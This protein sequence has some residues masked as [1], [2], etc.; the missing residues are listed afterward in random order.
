MNRR[1]FLYGCTS[2]ALANNHWSLTA[3]GLGGSQA[4][5]PGNLDE[6]L[7]GQPVNLALFG[8]LQSW[9]NPSQVRLLQDHP[10]QNSSG[11]LRL[12]DILSKDSEFDLGVAWPEFRTIHRLVVRFAAKDKCPQRG[13]QFVE[14]WDGISPLQGRWKLLE[15]ETNLGIPQGISLEVDGRIWT[16]N[17][18]DQRT[19]KIRLRLQNE[20]QVE[21]ESF[22][23]YGPSKWK[24]GEVRIE[25]GRLKQQKSYDGSFSIYNGAL[26]ELQPIGDTQLTEPSTW[27]ASPNGRMPSGVI[28][29]LLYTSGMDVDRTIATIRSNACD[30]SFLP[31]EALE[32]RPIDIAEFEVYIRSSSLNLDRA[33]YRMKYGQ[34]AR[35]I[36]AVSPHP[37]QTLEKA[38]QAIRARRVTLAFVGVDSNSHKF[39]IAPDGHV[40]VG[41]NDPSNGRQMVPKFSIYFASTEESTLFQEPS[42]AADLF[43]KEDEKLQQLEE[44]WLPMVTT[45]WSRNEVSFERLDYA[46][47]QKA[48]EPM[49]EATLLGNELALLISRLIIRNNSPV[50]KTISYYLKP[51]NQQ[52]GRVDYGAIPAN[53]T[54]AW[55]TALQGDSI[56]VTEGENEYTVCTIDLHGRG[57]L[58]MEATE[59]AVRYSVELNPGEEHTLHTTIPGRASPKRNARNSTISLTNRRV[60]QPSD[61]GRTASPKACK[62]RSQTSEFRISTMPLCSILCW[63][64]RK[65][66]NARNTTPTWR[67]SITEPLEARA[68]PSSRASTCVVYT[69]APKVA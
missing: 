27:T 7:A 20:R 49:D 10:G 54:N 63:C 30:F 69:G 66:R 46:T 26:L 38:Y 3:F 61:T 64:L 2:A 56:I 37:E 62:S 4:G 21:V 28:A 44:G 39:G 41:N 5:K 13:R 25:L 8:E 43:K 57:L 6:S 23:V 17:F 1:H 68:V 29:K 52:T 36:N 18:S 16:F 24:V 14:F 33:A 34:S 59:N 35:I 51:W 50:P 58:A 22:E 60:T 19:C 9:L 15:E 55:M 11:P 65:M 42:T 45:K 53:S 47:L 67:C 40:V 48:F 32:H 12:T 31:G